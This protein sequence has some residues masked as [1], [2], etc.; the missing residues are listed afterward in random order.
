MSGACWRWRARF[1]RLQQRPSYASPLA[2]TPRQCVDATALKSA[3]IKGRPSACERSALA[4]SATSW[5]TATV[6]WPRMMRRTRM[7]I[8]GVVTSRTGPQIM[9]SSKTPPTVAP[10]VVG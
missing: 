10:K 1:G 6:R 3:Y 8:I 4:R 9:V 5:V 7:K 2:T